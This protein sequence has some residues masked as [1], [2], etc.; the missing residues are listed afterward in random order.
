MSMEEVKTLDNDYFFY[1][2]SLVVSTS[3]SVTFWNIRFL[4][5]SFIRQVE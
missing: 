3:V 1:V 4:L 2:T 5:I